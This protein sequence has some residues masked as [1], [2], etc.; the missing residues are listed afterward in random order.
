MAAPTLS[1][2]FE[3]PDRAVRISTVLLALSSSG[4]AFVVSQTAAVLLEILP[5]E[6]FVFF[7]I[8]VNKKGGEGLTVVSLASPALFR[9]PEFVHVARR[10]PLAVVLALLQVAVSGTIVLETVTLRGGKRPEHRS[11]TVSFY[12]L[13]ISMA[14][15]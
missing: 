15:V 3:L 11:S 5:F 8:V 7:S 12:H 6:L 13:F 10:V 14:H 9:F 4:C 2:N 1:I